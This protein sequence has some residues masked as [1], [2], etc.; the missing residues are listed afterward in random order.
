M[1]ERSE[2]QI[3]R[4]EATARGGMVAAKTPQ[5]AAAGAEILRAGGNAVDAAVAT[6]LAAGVAEPWMNGLGG[7][8]FLVVAGPGVAPAA[9]VFPMA[10]PRGATPEMFPLSGAAA[11]EGPFGWPGVVGDANLHGPRSVAIPGTVAGLA[12]ALER[13]GTRP[14]AEAIAPAVRLAAEGVPVTWHTTLT[15]ARDLATL[16]RYPATAAVFLDGAGNPPVSLDQAAPTRLRQP[17]LARTLETIAAEGPRAFYEGPLAATMVAH[18]T[19]GGSPVVAA[20]FAAYEA[21]LAEPLAVRYAGHEVVTVGGGT[22]GTTLAE[23]LL[24][25]DALGVGRLGHNTPEALHRMTQAF[26]Q[27]FADRFA[28][29]ADPSF[30]DVPLAVLTDPAYA[31]ERAAA[32]PM[33]R[34]G[35]VAAGTADRVG[36]GHGLGA[37]VPGYAAAASG[38]QMADGSTTHLSVIDKNGL[39][40]SLTQTLLSLWGSRVTV[41]GTGVLLNNGM[42]WFDPEPGRPN[43]VAG[44]KTPLS[45]MA[46][47]LLLRD[48]RVVA[49]IGSSGGRRIMNC[50]AQLVANL[51][52]H[53]L[54]IGEALAAPRIDA[55]TPDLLASVRLPAATRQALTALGH[56]V[57]PRDERLFTGDFASP[58]AVVRGGDGS[59]AGAA[60]P[61]SFPATA[62][63]AG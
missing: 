26:R 2:W 4:T 37:S 63:G 25:M 7:G 42:M 27:A 9:V 13:F 57:A 53:G 5:A 55:S 12:L 46:P 21:R 41:P 61:F 54:G 51:L 39:A 24:L 23:S 28:W 20:D 22:G 56:R 14:L 17:D 62:V 58:C 1:G 45:N 6:A 19:E 52:D 35:S 49:S 3:G 59:L 11:D 29:L 30:V 32:F 60:D 33:D 31:A 43:S 40:V 10:A 16:K 44:G 15:V 47:A 8:G 50:H 34:L 36:V 38:G 18:L 48:G